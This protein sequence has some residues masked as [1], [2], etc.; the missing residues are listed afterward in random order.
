M[1]RRMP[2][3][4]YLRSGYV[5]RAG[6][7]GFA[8]MPLSSPATPDST[9]LL[10]NARREKYDAG[11]ISLRRTFAGA[12]EWFVGY[13]RSSA[14]SNAAVDFSLENPIFANQAPGPQPWDTPNRIHTWGWAPLPVRLL[15]ARLHWIARNTTVAYL[16]EYRT[17]FPFGI[18]S[19]DGSLLGSPNSMRMPDYFNV[20]LHLERQF[21]ALHWL[22]AWRFGFNNLTNN[23]NPNVVNNVAGTPAFLTY[24]RGQARAFSV[25]LRLL[26]RK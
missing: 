7:R 20:N 24:G 8:F 6:D 15:P 13:T 12:F 5:H 3:G 10:R 23:G 4:F 19:E 25:R 18:V 21:R 22:W 1:E 26:G 2:L 17:G 14:R 11:E 16:V 9:Y